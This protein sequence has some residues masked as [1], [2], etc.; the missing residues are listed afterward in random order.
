MPEIVIVGGPPAANR[1]ATVSASALA[2]H[3][4]CTRAYIRKLE[5]DGVIQRQGEGF[6][7][8]QNRVAY[9]RFLRRE[10]RQSRRSEADAEHAAAKAAW[11]KL[12]IAKERRQLMPISDHNNF[13]DD[14]VGILLT[15]LG[16]LPARLAGMDLGARKKVE[17]VVLE[18]RRE[19][20]EVCQQ[21]ANESGEPDEP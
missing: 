16:S 1:A 12:R 5:V 21:R 8:D 13:V 19:I 2:A 7:L 10:R 20:A 14:L 4:D 18:L 17:I 3:L 9:L 11:L 6:P 15:K